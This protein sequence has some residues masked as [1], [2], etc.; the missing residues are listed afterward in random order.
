MR[1]RS[2]LEGK[3]KGIAHQFGFEQYDA[4]ILENEELYLRKAG[5][6]ISEQ[7]FCFTDKGGRRVTLRPELTPSLARMILGKG[8]SL[9]FPLKWFSIPQCWRYEK[10]S[11]G[12]RR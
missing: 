1:V 5:E 10:M 9:T 12:R 7:L 3:W 11:R 8:K 6:E 2:W 4:P